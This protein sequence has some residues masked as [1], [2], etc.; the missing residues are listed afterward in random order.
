MSPSRHCF[1]LY[2]FS[3]VEIFNNKSI[4]IIHKFRVVQRD[5][6]LSPDLVQTLLHQEDQFTMSSQTYAL[7]AASIGNLLPHL[8]C[9]DNHTYMLASM[10]QVSFE[11]TA[12]IITF[13][14]VHCFESTHLKQS[15]T[16]IKYSLHDFD[17]TITILIDTA[18]PAFKV[19][20]I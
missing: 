5:C 18:H 16:L 20:W 19:F 15:F 11:Y 13:T 8:C 12:Q 3:K 17:L 10:A 7:K 1:S 14:G 2:S 4:Q 9:I 6:W